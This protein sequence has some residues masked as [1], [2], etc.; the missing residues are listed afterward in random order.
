[1]AA[2]KEVGDAIT[3]IQNGTQKNI[4]NVDRAVRMIDDATGLASKSG[5]L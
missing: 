3:G 1:M 2:T 5:K 4:G